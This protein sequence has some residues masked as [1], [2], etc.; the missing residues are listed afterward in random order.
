MKAL[1]YLV[2]QRFSVSKMYIFDAWRKSKGFLWSRHVKDT[3]RNLLDH[4]T[5]IAL[6]P[7]FEYTQDAVIGFTASIFERARFLDNKQSFLCLPRVWVGH[8]SSIDSNTTTGDE[9]F[10]KPLHSTDYGPGPLKVLIDRLCELERIDED[11]ATIIAKYSEVCK[12]HNLEIFDTRSFLDDDSRLSESYCDAV[13][14]FKL[15]LETIGKVG[16]L[17]VCFANLAN[18]F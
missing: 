11:I 14:F 18:L 12:T 16:F 6:K 10:W 3:K 9:I 13:N 5:N 8:E 17:G 7:S 15:Q 1:E 4:W 2:V